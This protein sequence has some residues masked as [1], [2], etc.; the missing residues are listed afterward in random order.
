M[1]ENAEV[2]DSHKLLFPRSVN[3]ERPITLEPNAPYKDRRLKMCC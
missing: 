2:N 1:T 3:G